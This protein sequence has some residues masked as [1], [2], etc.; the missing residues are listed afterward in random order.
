MQNWRHVKEMATKACEIS[1]WREWLCVATLAAA[2]AERGEF[3]EAIKWQTKAMAMSQPAEERDQKDNDERLQL[4]R[5]GKPFVMKMKESAT[6]SAAPDSTAPES[7][8]K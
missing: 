4:Y 1:K 7:A 2:C 8:N 5:A 3:E 6:D